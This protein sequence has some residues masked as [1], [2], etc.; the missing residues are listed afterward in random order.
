MSEAR[1][2]QYFKKQ[3]LPVWLRRRVQIGRA[4]VPLL[5]W[6]QHLSTVLPDDW[7]YDFIY[8]VVTTFRWL[9]PPD[10]LPKVWSLL[11][12]SNGGLYLRPNTWLNYRAHRSDR[13]FDELVTADTIGLIATILA[14]NWRLSRLMDSANYN[15]LA[16]LERRLTAFKNV[17]PEHVGIQAVID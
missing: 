11:A 12:L 6:R 2:W 16:K 4:A 13:N 10:P 8:D 7:Q 9:C 17:H 14:V 3:E 1:E 5:E 15:R